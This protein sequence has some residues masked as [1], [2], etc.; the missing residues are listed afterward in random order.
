MRNAV[1]ISGALG[2]TNTERPSPLTALKGAARPM[3]KAHYTNRVACVCVYCGGKFSLPACR[4]IKDGMGRVCPLCRHPTPSDRFWRRVKRAD[5]CWLWIGA[6]HPK[7][8]GYA[9]L[10]G[11]V[12]YAHRV[13]WQLTYGSIPDGREVC[14]RC[15]NPPCCN[16]AHLFIGTH[17]DNMRDMAHKG[18]ALAAALK[19]AKLTPR[20][21]AVI[22]SRLRAGETQQ[23]IADDYSVTRSAI[24]YIAQGRRWSHIE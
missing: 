13:A 18:R 9:S 17:A 4:V 16:P 10:D 23:S 20:S 21:V 2:A 12:Q 1:T 6:R 7:G 11:R 24:G 14:H 3:A 8:H 15:D 22:K 19:R 5:G